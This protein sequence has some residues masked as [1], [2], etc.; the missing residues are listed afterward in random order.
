MKVGIGIGLAS[1]LIGAVLMMSGKQMCRTS[2]WADN[3]FKI[4]LPKNY[5]HLAGGMPWVAMGIAI[6]AYAI[7]RKSKP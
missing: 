6:A 3:L 5:E 7:W 2:C 1:I 4:F